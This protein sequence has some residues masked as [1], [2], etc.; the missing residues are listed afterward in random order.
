[1][2]YNITVW[3]LLP[4][5]QILWTK[6]DLL[7]IVFLDNPFRIA[8]IIICRFLTVRVSLNGR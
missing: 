8:R 7:D 1:M 4:I 2:A 5:L 6:S 3:A